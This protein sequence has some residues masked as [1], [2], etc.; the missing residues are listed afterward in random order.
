M[1]EPVNRV[2]WD[3]FCVRMIESDF[4]D[5]TGIRGSLQNGVSSS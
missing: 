5:R 2:D 1:P 3:S 4:E